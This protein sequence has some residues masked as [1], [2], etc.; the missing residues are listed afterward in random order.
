MRKSAASGTIITLVLGVFGAFFRWL[1]NTSAFDPDTGFFLSG[2]PITA[3]LIVYYVLAAA[4]IC[5]G[6]PMLLRQ[7]TC[8]SDV[9]ALRC[10]TV[11]PTGICWLLAV[12][13]V[14]ASC[15]MMFSADLTPYPTAQ[16]LLGAAGILAGLCFPLLPGK[17]DGSA[18]GLA[19]PA[20]AFM[21]L[22]CSYWLVY[23]YR[24]HSSD[25]IIWGFAIEILAVAATAVAM[26]YAASFHYGAAK[27]IR[28]IA[29]AALAAFFNLAT[30]F[31]SRSTASLLMTVCMAAWMLLLEYLLLENLEETPRTH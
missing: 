19:R 8:P 1:Q 15:V 18:A 10:S 11:I 4:A 6:V 5:I 12:L 27:P 23:C 13:F 14:L 7:Y 17:R 24:V 31:D 9:R 29:A 16:R 28:A 25:P 22:F 3:V 2:R 30:L 21:T 20:A 26:Y